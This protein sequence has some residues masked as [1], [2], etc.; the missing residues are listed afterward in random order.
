[1]GIY[2]EAISE[3]YEDK[4]PGY[5][6]KC[7]SYNCIHSNKE[8]KSEVKVNPHKI[9]KVSLS[10]KEQQLINVERLLAC[11]GMLDEKSKHM[12]LDWYPKELRD[13]ISKFMYNDVYEIVKS[14]VT[15]I[16]NNV[17]EE[18][19]NNEEYEEYQA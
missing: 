3:F 10:H 16:E 14:L 11:I 19:E 6:Y 8:S 5:C 17:D 12:C 15:W 18:Y 1:M 13:S 7:M 9:N 4:K 2:D